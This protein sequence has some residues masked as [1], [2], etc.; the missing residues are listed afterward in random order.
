MS[1]QNNKILALDEI[2]TLRNEKQMLRD[3]IIPVLR[4]L[5]HYHWN[6]AGWQGHIEQL[7]RIL[8]LTDN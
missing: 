7:T 6:Q 2:L 8:E 1:K 4:D 3:A 5:R